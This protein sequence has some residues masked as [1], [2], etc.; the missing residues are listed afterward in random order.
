[1]KLWPLLMVSFSSTPE[2]ASST[3]TSNIPR[4]ENPRP[5]NLPWRGHHKTLQEQQYHGLS[6]EQI[7]MDISPLRKDAK[8]EHQGKCSYPSLSNSTWWVRSIEN[9]KFPMHEHIN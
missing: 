8:Q 2:M 4:R 5:H 3:T 7:I 6:L 1:M 9:K